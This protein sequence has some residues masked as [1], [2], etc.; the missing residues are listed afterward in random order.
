MWQ[1]MLA[2]VLQ[3][4]YFSDASIAE[5]IAFGIPKRRALLTNKQIE[6]VALCANKHRPIWSYTV[7][8][9]NVIASAYTYVTC[10]ELKS[11]D[12]S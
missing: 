3:H 6:S 9:L 2:H 11:V 8:I 4:I 10:N 12:Y 7:H 1:K 5:N